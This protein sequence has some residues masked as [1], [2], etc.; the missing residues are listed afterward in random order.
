MAR[1]HYSSTSQPVTLTAGITNSNTSLPVSSTAGYPTEPF[2]IAIERGTAN[3]EAC[4]VTDVPDANHFTVTR[5]YAGTTAVAHDTGKPVE[6]AVTSEDYDEANEFINTPA[7]WTVPVGTMLPFA[8]A[9]G[10]VPSGWLLCDGSAVARATY[11]DLHTLLKDADGANS[12]PYGTG[13]GS[14][15]FNVPD[16]RGRIPLGKDNMGGPSANRVVAAAADEVG[17]V[18]GAEKHTLT[19][20]EMPSHTHVQN[21]H[22]HGPGSGSGY[23]T[24]G[25]N[26]AG[27]LA[28]SSGG[29]VQAN[30]AYATPTNQNTGGGAAHNNMQPYMTVNM[31]IKAAS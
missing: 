20:T 22:R 15:T 23:V 18:G 25:V 19:T 9:S 21:Q 13:D 27:G 1:R 3:E 6:H 7:L 4:L 16:L 31:I 8:G 2:T 14:T 24:Y 28:I 29:D 11:P 26:D 10:S 17:G 12:Y 30:T 5:G